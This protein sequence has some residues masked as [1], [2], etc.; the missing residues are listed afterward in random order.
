ML[1]DMNINNK[2]WSFLGI[3]S[4]TNENMSNPQPIFIWKKNEI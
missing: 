3:V 4:Y 1:D 2:Q